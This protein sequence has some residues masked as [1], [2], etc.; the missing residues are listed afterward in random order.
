MREAR[1]GKR[2][3]SAFHNALLKYGLDSFIIETVEECDTMD[4]LSER[5]RHW[6]GPSHY[7]G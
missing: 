7:A 4:E 6:T 3:K 1:Y 2:N 5:E